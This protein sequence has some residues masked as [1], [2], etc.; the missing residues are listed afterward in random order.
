M[1][2]RVSVP[3]IMVLVFGSHGQDAW[4]LYCQSSMVVVFQQ[5]YL[6]RHVPRG[7]LVIF[8]SCLDILQAPSPPFDVPDL[9]FAYVIVCCAGRP[10]QAVYRL[11]F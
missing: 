11:A 2:G 7:I 1:L 10:Y 5:A 3:A 6:A 8:T 9:R 4:C